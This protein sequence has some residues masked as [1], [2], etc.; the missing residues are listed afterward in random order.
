MEINTTSCCGLNE[1]ENISDCGNGYKNIITQIIQHREKTTED[2]PFYIFTDV[3][4]RI[5]GRRLASFIELN[6][7]GKIIKSHSK[8]NPNSENYISVWIWEVSNKGLKDY[9]NKNLWN[10]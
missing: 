10:F 4:R 2:I 8:L 7:L 3:T 6:K 5:S 1:L 9:Q